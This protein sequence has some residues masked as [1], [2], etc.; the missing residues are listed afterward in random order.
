MIILDMKIS[1]T[2]SSIPLDVYMVPGSI[3][4]LVLGGFDLDGPGAH[5]Q[6]EVQA[7]VQQLDGKEV[8]LGVLLACLAV[9][10]LSVGE[11]DEA[12]GLCSTEVKGDGTHTLGVP[13]GQADVGFGRFKGNGVQRR[14]VL[15]LEV[16]V[17]LDLHLWVSDPSQTG[18]LQTDVV[19]FVDNLCKNKTLFLFTYYHFRNAKHCAIVCLIF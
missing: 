17:T 6:Q 7:T 14:H 16:G 2:S 18:Q 5:V 1:L 3:V 15:T 12:V 8:H 4:D 10:R 11:E 13:F 9:L 19:V